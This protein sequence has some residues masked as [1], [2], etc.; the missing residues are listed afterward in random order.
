MNTSPDLT[1]TA[2]KMIFAL[3]AILFGIIAIYYLTKKL[4]INSL[5]GKDSGYINIIENKY[6][7]VKKSLCLVKIPRICSGP[8]A[9][10]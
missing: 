1:I 7:G 3:I 6:L 4:S 10:E 5:H 9:F 2:I 8:W